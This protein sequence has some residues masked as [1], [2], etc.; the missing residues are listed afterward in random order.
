MAPIFTKQPA[1]ALGRDVLEYKL[2][3]AHGVTLGH[4]IPG[5]DGPVLA[6]GAVLDLLVARHEAEQRCGCG[7]RTARLHG[8]EG[9]N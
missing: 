5:D 7:R 2:E 1:P 8:P 9:R 6:D 3:C 4:V